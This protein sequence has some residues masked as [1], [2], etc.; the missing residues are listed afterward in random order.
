MNRY[1]F[2]EDYKEVFRNV[3]ASR[4]IKESVID[5]LKKEERSKIMK[6]QKNEKRKKKWRT[7]ATVA[8]A[9]LGI[10]IVS[11]GICLAATGKTWISQIDFVQNGEVVDSREVQW[12]KDESTGYYIGHI[13]ISDPEKDSFS[14][15][16]LITDEDSLSNY[17]IMTDEDS[18]SNENPDDESYETITYYD[19]DEEWS[20]EKMW[21]E[22]EGEDVIL[23]AGDVRKDITNDFD[24]YG[25]AKGTIESESYRNG[26]SSNYTVFKISEDEY[27]VT[28]EYDT[29]YVEYDSQEEKVYLYA[30]A[31]SYDITDQFTD[32]VASG[33]IE[34]ESYRDGKKTEYIVTKDGNHISLSIGPKTDEIIVP[35]ISSSTKTDQ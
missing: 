26:K 14:S 32:G 13:S 5:I 34:E 17:T 9:V 19:A 20:V 15:Y 23:C 35:R 6:N 18:L 33:I 11:N 2:K 8:A 24:S 10:V 28:P 30:G 29:L 31:K 16:T 3:N 4:K 7:V 12:E 21:I 1:N 25:M 27:T 22:Q